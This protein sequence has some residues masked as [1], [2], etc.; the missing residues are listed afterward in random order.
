[1]LSEEFC[2]WKRS[3]LNWAGKAENAYIALLMRLRQE[4]GEEAVRNTPEKEKLVPTMIPPIPQD[5][6]EKLNKLR[7]LCDK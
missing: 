2:V 6:F 1:M 4:K 5:T 3:G 7:R